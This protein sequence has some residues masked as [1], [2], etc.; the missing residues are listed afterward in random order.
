M[1]TSPLFS[2]EPSGLK[3][4]AFDDSKRRSFAAVL[5]SFRAEDGFPIDFVYARKLE[6]TAEKLSRFESSA[7]I[8]FNADG[9][10][11]DRKSVV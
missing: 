3:K 10:V 1:S 2:T 11:L 8:F 4:V 7:A 5:S 9:A 6:S